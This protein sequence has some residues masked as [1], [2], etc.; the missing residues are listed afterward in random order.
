M[1][2]GLK[3]EAKANLLEMIPLERL[4]SG[5]DVAKAVLF[6]AGEDSS[7]IT[8]QVLAVNGGIYM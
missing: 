2:D 4:G 7:Y 3:E 6:L 8:G 1:T 5:A